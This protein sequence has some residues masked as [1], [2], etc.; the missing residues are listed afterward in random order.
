MLL[1]ESVEWTLR[2]CA[3]RTG[4]ESPDPRSDKKRAP[5]GPILVLAER[6]GWIRAFGPHPFGAHCVRPQFRLRRCLRRTELCIPCSLRRKNKRGPMGPFVHV[7]SER[8]MDSGLRPSPLRGALRASAIAPLALL[9]SNRILHPMLTRPEKE[10]GPDGPLFFFWRRER[11][12]NPRYAIN[13]YSLSRGALS[14][15]QPSLR[16]RATTSAS[17]PKYLTC[18]TTVRVSPRW[19]RHGTYGARGR[20]PRA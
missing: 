6:E 12:S 1:A 18:R 8:G 11:D 14:T 9:A 10:E 4:V 20:Q 7:V 16:I 13:V 5:L 3:R 17:V 15:T 19:T 2:G